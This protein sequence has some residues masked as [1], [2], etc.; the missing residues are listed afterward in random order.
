[1]C[2]ITN[3]ELLDPLEYSVGTALSTS[4]SSVHCYFMYMIGLTKRSHVAPKIQNITF[5]DS[6][7][8]LD[9]CCKNRI[10]SVWGG[11]GGDGYP[12]ICVKDGSVISW[13]RGEGRPRRV[14]F[15]WTS[16]RSALVSNASIN[17]EKIIKLQ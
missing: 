9:W 4:L 15:C 16:V 1:M 10:D 11:G 2:Y 8:R 5:C 13:G 6:I 12:F 3:R 17:E 7:V 14:A